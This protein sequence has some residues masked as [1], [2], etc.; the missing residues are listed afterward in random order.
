MFTPIDLTGDGAAYVRVSD[1]QQDTQRQYA[2]VHAFEQRFGVT[3]PKAH[4][5]EDLGWARDT[6]DVRPA[7]QRL[8]ELVEA[9]RIKWIVVDQ[10]DRFGTKDAHQLIAYLHRLREAGCRLYDA[11]GKDWTDADIATVINAVIKGDQSKKEQHGMSH[12]VLG[13]KIGFARAGEWQGG[14]VRLGFDVAC[15]AADGDELWRV[16]FLGRVGG[17]LRRLK[18]WPDGRTEAFDGANNF[19]RTQPETEVLRLTPSRDRA[20]LDAVRSVFKRYATESVGFTAL[21]HYLNGLK[22][23]NSLGGLFQGNQIEG[24]LGDPSYLGYV[25][26]NRRHGGKFHVWRGGR[27]VQEDNLSK[28]RTANPESDW[29]QSPRLFEP[30]VDAK[31]WAAVQK[32]L[33]R[34]TKRPRESPSA[35]L[36]LSG[37]VVCATCG[38]EMVGHPARRQTDDP[39]GQHEFY[40]STYHKAVRDRWRKVRRGGVEVRVGPD[41][42]ECRCGYH[43]VRQDALGPYIE[44]YLD[45]AG[46]RLALLGMTPE[47][48]PTGRLEEAEG[49]AWRAYVEGFARLCTYLSQHHPEEYAA[50]LAEDAE[51]GRLEAGGTGEPGGLADLDD[52]TRARLDEAVR[53]HRGDATRH[54]G[55]CP[56]E[57]EFLGNALAA[58]RDCFDPGALRAE[59]ERLEAEHTALMHRYADLPTPRARDKAKAELAALE[60]RIAQLEAQQQDAGRAVTA[61]LGELRDLA[62]AIHDA[63][64]ALAAGDGERALR[65]RAEALRAVIHRIECAFVPTGANGRGRGNQ[66]TRLARVT[67]HPLAGA[68]KEYAADNSLQ[69]LPVSAGT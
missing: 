10:L 43:C 24:M 56:R 40:C 1:D 23:R 18:V 50:L 22:F 52:V 49:G 28:V 35:G 64:K 7:F 32:K 68:A 62:Q 3:I 66:A 17:V 63:R 47:T 57:G 2:A 9:G 19:P 27:A 30:I 65:R 15:H 45:E 54:Y 12:R 21:A 58:Y 53:K 16:V 6:A 42:Q 44:R 33:A 38:Q 61:A 60:A 36:V 69:D 5:F 41:G 37:L 4:W 59:V 34:R 46:R 31:T 48:A 14:Q 29:V 11:E 51:R 67:V 39:T 13:A 8:L 26:Y 55:P 25:A 20:K